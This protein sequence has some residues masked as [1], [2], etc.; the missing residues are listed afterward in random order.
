[1]TPD[2]LAVI[3]N[4]VL[5][6]RSQVKGDNVHLRLHDGDQLAPYNHLLERKN[7]LAPVAAGAENW[8]IE[9]AIP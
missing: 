3:E 6:F 1:M 7:R 5:F 4:D 9:R 2:Q 8:V